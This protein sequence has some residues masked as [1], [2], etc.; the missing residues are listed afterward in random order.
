MFT[1]TKRGVLEIE[2]QTT[3]ADPKP[4]ADQDKFGFAAEL[5]GADDD[6]FEL[7]D[8]DV[9]TVTNIVP[10]SYS[11]A[12]NDPTPGYDLTALSCNDGQSTTPSTT[13]LGTRTATIKVDPG[14]TVR[15]VFT[16]TKRGKL[17]I[18]KQ[19][20][21][22]DPEAE[23]DQ[24]KFAFTAE[25]PGADDDA[26]ELD[27]D[28][29]RTVSNIV[30]GSYSVSENDPTPGYDLTDLTC[31]D[32]QS[33]TPSTPTSVPVRRRSR[34]IRARRSVVSSRTQARRPRD[35][36]ADDAGRSQAGGRSGQV[37]LHGRPPGRRR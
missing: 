10:G 32:G 4:E 28:D 31:D 24:D 25:L 21:P 8:D 36:E 7:D 26:F 18:E 29:V 14:E 33:T 13:N 16:N 6:A 17:E 27:D 35:R 11:V 12:E 22:D 19:T 34:S 3:P 20:S 30:P 15:C 23:A 1:N 2:K 9:K 37:R 5:P